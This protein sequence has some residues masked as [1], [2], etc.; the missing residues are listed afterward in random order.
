VLRLAEFFGGGLW[1]FSRA[2][3]GCVTVLMADFVPFNSILVL[4]IF[5]A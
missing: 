5:C 3:Q 4:F 2:S 1:F